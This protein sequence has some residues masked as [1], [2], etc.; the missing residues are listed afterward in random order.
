MNKKQK[1]R[2]IINKAKEEGVK[3]LDES[4]SKSILS[5]AGINVVE[6]RELTNIEDLNNIAQIWGYPLVL[7]GISKN[8]PHKSE[9]GL[10]LTD[11]Y[12]FEDL[13]RGYESLESKKDLG[14]EKIIVQPQIKGTREFVVGM[15]RD[16]DF[17]PVVMFGLGGIFTEALEDFSLRV[18]PINIDEAKRCINEIRSKPLLGDFRGER[19]VSIEKLAKILVALSDLAL[20][21]EDIKEID[22]NPIKITRDGDV[23]AVDALLGI[24]TN[25]IKKEHPDRIDPKHFRKFFYPESVVFIGAS[26]QIGKWGHLLPTLLISGEYEGEIYLL[27]KKG[28]EAFGRKMYTDLSQIPDSIDLAIVTIPA[29]FVI[30]LIPRLAQKRINHLLLISSGFSETGE[31]G[32]KLQKRLVQVAKENNVFIIGPNTMGVCNPHAKFHCIGTLIHPRPGSTAM[33]SQSGNMGVQLLSFATEQGIGIRGFCGS[34]NEAMICIEDYLEAFYEDDLTS[35][36]MMYIESVKNG[37][38]FFELAKKISKK[39]PIILLKG[40]ETDAGIDAAETHTGAMATNT[41]VFNTVC[42]QSGILKV[43]APSELLTMAA[44]FSSLPIPK[45][46]RVVIISLGGGWAVITADLCAKYGLEL[47]KLP[48]EVIE[49][50]DEKLPDFW[51]RKNPIDL[52]GEWNIELPAAILD[53]VLSW[54]GCDAVINLGILGRKFYIRKYTD[55]VLKS[56]PTYTKEYLDNIKNMVIEHENKFAKICVDMME[57]YEKPIFGVRLNTEPDDKT[58]YEVPG[59]RYKTV[60]YNSPED[61]VR[62]CARMYEYFLWLTRNGKDKKD[63]Q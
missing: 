7:K 61:A 44:S 14:I 41:R 27:N 50:I 62:A 32:K 1:I 34:G 11:L 2:E 4:M 29:K 10:V 26:S 24:E 28:G 30:G 12:N 13:K 56:D 59:A 53:K 37:R 39:K 33:V 16:P 23:I 40:G 58:V 42:K 38:R 17:G 6:E 5:L 31:Q 46:N 18:C 51:S 49:L 55:A 3:T 48:K 36:L 19:A 20:E 54:D 63:S 43:D 8:I 25:P 35:T 47:S 22:I 21:F 15:F 52:V 57:K 45:G 60:C 9:M